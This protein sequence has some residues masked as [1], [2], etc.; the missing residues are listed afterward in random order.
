[1]CF[2]ATLGLK[3]NLAKSELVPLGNVT[4]GKVGPNYRVWS[5]HST[6]QASRF[7]VGGLLQ[8]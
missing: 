4:R 3:V 1:M 6:S 7:T 8:G 2:E 5:L